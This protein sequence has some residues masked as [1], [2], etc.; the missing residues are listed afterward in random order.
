MIVKDIS[1]TYFRNFESFKLEFSDNINIFHGKNGAGK[2]NLL[3]AV[4]VNLLARSPRGA[5][6]SVMVR[7]D[8]DYYRVESDVDIDERKYKIAVAYQKGGR[9]KISIDKIAAKASE[10][11]Q[12]CTVVSTAPHDIEILS[13]PPSKRREFIDV[14]LS[15]AYRKYICDIT[16]Y[17]KALSQKNALLKQDTMVKANPYDELLIQYGTDLIMA[18]NEFIKKIS[19]RAAE[20]YSRISGGQKFEMYYKPS[21]IIPDE[22]I[23]YDIVAKNFKEKLERNRDREKAMQTAVVGPHRDEVEFFIRDYPARTHGSQGELRTAAISLKMAVYDFLKEVRRVEPVLLLDEIF[24]ELDKGRKDML[25][26]RFEKF[27][28]IFLTTAGTIP[29]SLEKDARKFKIENGA[30]IPA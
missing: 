14:H 11:F 17:Y 4:F 26:E 15:Q 6:D 10:L 27:G 19:D 7:E 12:Y 29:E 24:A 3:E 2:T 23:N 20:H 16:D 8:E 25:V 18:R 22:N 28:Q 9:K 13:G 21:V 30:V 5:N 1:L